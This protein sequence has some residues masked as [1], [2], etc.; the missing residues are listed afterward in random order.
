MPTPP[1]AYTLT[2]NSTLTEDFIHSDSILASATASTALATFLN[3]QGQSEA[4]V[5]YEDGELCHL[6][7]EPLSSSGWNFCG[8]GAVIESIT[9]A[10]SG[11]VWITDKAQGIWMSNAGHWNFISTFPG[12]EPSLSV[13]TTGTVYGLVNQDHNYHLY[14]FDPVSRSFDDHGIVPITLAPVG[15]PDSLWSIAGGKL[16]TNQYGSW[17][18]VYAPFESGDVPSRVSIGGDDSIWILCGN[19]SIYSYDPPSVTCKKLEHVPSDITSFGAVSARILYVL[20]IDSRESRV[21]T[22][23]TG[24]WEEIPYP[25]TPINNISVG[26]DGSLWALDDRGR[27]WL[28]FDGAWVRQI[29]PTDLSGVTG[30]HKVT[31]VVI[32]QH[33]NGGIQ[34]AFFIMNNNLWSAR[35]VGTIGDY[36]GYWT[37]IGQVFA[38]CSSIAAVNDPANYALLIYGVSVGGNF[39]LVQYNESNKWVAAEHTIKPSLKGIRPHFVFDGSWLT[40]AVINSQLYVG[41]GSLRSPAPTLNPAK[42][43]GAPAR[44]QSLISFSTSPH[45]MSG[46]LLAAIDSLNQVWIVSGSGGTTYFTQLSNAVEPGLGPV[47]GVVAMLRP[48]EGARLYARDRNNM[49]W[50]IRQTGTIINKAPVPNTIVWSDWHPLGNTCIALGTGCTIPAPGSPLSAPVDLFSL[51]AGYEVNVL[52]ED[53]TT[54]ALTDL[55]MLK[56][57]GTNADAEY[58][59]RYVSQITVSGTD[60]RTG[61]STPQ[62]EFQL[63]VTSSEAIGIWVGSNLYNVSSEKPALLTTD[64]LGRIT[65]AFFASDLHTPTF[66]FKAEGLNDPPS[67]YPAH[68]INKYLAG[69]SDAI[70]NRPVFTPDGSALLNAQMQTG[71]G[72]N[73]DPT[74]FV[75]S[76]NKDKAPKVA[77]AITSIYAL[78]VDPDGTSGQ[79]S[80]AAEQ[81]ADM[82]ASGFWHDLCKFPHDI[83]HAIKQDALKVL[84][85]V[86]KV[87]ERVVAFTMQLASGLSQVLHLAINTIRDIVSA[88]KSVFRYVER[89]IEEA[90]DWLKALF[91]WNDIINTKN[92]IEACLNGIMTKLVENFNPNSPVYAGTLFDKYMDELESS[93]LSGFDKAKEHFSR[94]QTFAQCADSVP[95]PEGARPIGNNPLDPASLQ[96]AQTSNGTQTN[97][98]HTHVN[99]YTNQGGT[100]PTGDGSSDNI[101]QSFFES[102]ERNLKQGKF[103]DEHMKTIDSLKSIFSDPANFANVVMYDIITAFEDL[104]DILL[105]VIQGVIDALISLTGGAIAGFQVMM[106]KPINIP[107][108]SWIYRE[109]AHHPL[110]ILDL[111]CLILAVPVT[112]LYKLTFGLPHATAPFTKQ[113]ADDIVATLSNPATFP[114][115]AIACTGAS[116]ANLPVGSFPFPG[117]QILI[118]MSY[119]ALAMADM[120]ADAIAFLRK[121]KSRLPTPY[122]KDGLALFVGGACIV[123]SLIT[124]WL[125]APFSLFPGSGNTTGEKMQL[126]FWGLGFSVVAIDLVFVGVAL[127]APKCNL[128][129]GVPVLSATGCLLTLMG[130]ATT[131]VQI[132]ES[133]GQEA[134]FNAF[135]GITNEITSLPTALTDLL[136]TEGDPESELAVAVLVGADWVFDLASGALNFCSDLLIS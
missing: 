11:S 117:S 66:F 115:P 21:L 5:T 112:L 32:G 116:N 70:P 72:W 130:L 73:T 94:H 106:N 133:K 76:Q 44:L 119:V 30:G 28:W 123:C 36:G 128:P 103:K 1:L 15:K 56:P 67:L 20:T 85:I 53:A 65:F 60:S 47:Q 42:T 84:D 64:Q 120:W 82:S 50:I 136:L 129:Y 46:T 26:G 108:I 23:A 45:G 118:P 7:R 86:V 2:V 34:Y 105:K 58:V 89:G 124:H 102:I 6:Q 92:V 43:N 88:V 40:Y 99:N 75:Q 68:A 33:S 95:Y 38:G 132:Y 27:S 100:F 134:E 135:Q 18:E 114:W 125:T 16:F 110:T 55:V 83:E 25:A 80:V 81:P 52:S 131:G 104:V 13:G 79:W 98:V 3:S 62:V 127:I 71:P 12:G 57:D 24:T 51:D 121:D 74:P 109:V 69:D 111:F 113:Q 10:N 48:V 17:H 101:L 90:I 19:G 77:D 87:E 35:L 59:T 14:I 22:N 9:A 37:E 61:N 122:T 91:N 8:I 63:E 54:G 41:Q 49:L 31:E 78:P 97:Y 96:G 39:V 93:V 126:S 107:V 4:L 29:T